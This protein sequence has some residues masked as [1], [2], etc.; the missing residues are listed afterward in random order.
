MIMDDIK[1]GGNY[2]PREIA[3]VKSEVKLANAQ[4]LVSKKVITC[5]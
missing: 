5:H 4:L 2:T 1:A 3:P